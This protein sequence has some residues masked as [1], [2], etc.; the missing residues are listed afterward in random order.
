MKCLFKLVLVILVLTWSNVSI[1]DGVA[2]PKEVLESGGICLTKAQRDKLSEAV[3]ELQDI[4]G[5]KAE[6]ELQEPIV[7]VRDWEDRVFINGGKKKPIKL[8]LRVG[9]HV[10]RDL[11]VQ[12]PI[13][14][15]YRE[16][17]PDPMF[18]LRIRAQLGVLVPQLVKTVE[19]ATFGDQNDLEPFWD[20]GIGWDFF[21][22]QDLS[23]NVAAYTGIRSAGLGAGLDLTKNFGVY[24]GYGITYDGWSHTLLTSVYFAFN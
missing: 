15:F 1:A 9:K 12:L 4:H 19:G 2:C 6:I 18:R 17:P 22:I 14:V 16:E 20:A 21:H 3:L 8:K 5:S 7:I 13:Q 11:E 23:L 10:D 24:A